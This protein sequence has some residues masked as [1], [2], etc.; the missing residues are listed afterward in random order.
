[1]KTITKI[2]ML[3]ALC[4]GLTF[5]FTAC[6]QNEEFE[7][8]AK[9]VVFSAA[10]SYENLPETKTEYSGEDFNLVGQTQG[11][12]RIDWDTF[13]DT[14]RV[15][16]TNTLTAANYK[17]TQIT[18][19]TTVR[20]VANV[21]ATGDKLTWST[22]NQANTFYAVYPYTAMNSGPYT[23][24][25]I[26]TVIGASIPA[27]QDQDETHEGKNKNTNP[28]TTVTIT[29][30]TMSKY[31]FMVAKVENAANG[32]NVTLPFVP[33]FTAFEFCVGS[34]NDGG[35]NT[36]ISKVE[37]TSTSTALTGAWTW[38]GSAFDCP[39]YSSS[40]NKITVNYTNNITFNNSSPLRFTVFALPQNLDNVSVTFY[41]SHG[42]K[43]LTFTGKTFTGGNKY[44]I[45]TPGLPT[46]GDW[47]YFL[48]EIDDITTYGHLA[49]SSDVDVVS[50]RARQVNGVVDMSTIQPVTWKSQYFDGTQW[51]DW[52]S[53][54]GDFSF[55]S[56]YTGSGVS[57][58]SNSETRTVSLVDNTN[59]S[60]TGH[61]SST[62][63]LRA[64]TPVSNYSL[65]D[66][67]LY[68]QSI[69]ASTANTYVVTAPGTYTF[70]AVY[71]NGIENAQYN[72][73]A[74]FP[75]ITA[76]NCLPQFRNSVNAGITDPWIYTDLNSGHGLTLSGVD[77]EVV[78][79][80]EEIITSKPSVRF[81]EG[82]Y[83]IDFAINASDIRPGNAVIALRGKC[84][85]GAGT[86]LGD[87]SILW[88]WQ[89]W[90]TDQNLTPVNDLMPFNLGWNVDGEVQTI[91]YTNRELPI[92][93]LQ[94]AP[95]DDQYG[96][97][98]H[99]DFTFTQL[100]DAAQTYEL[101]IGSNP[102]YQWG[103][104]DPMLPG[105]YSAIPN[106]R[107][108]YCEDRPFYPST[109]YSGMSS[110][111][112]DPGLQSYIEYGK[113]V[114]NPHKGYQHSV[115]TGWI[116]GQVTLDNVAPYNLW[117]A[118]ITSANSSGTGDSGSSKIKTV[119][120]P[121]PYGFTVPYQSK[122]TSFVQ[123]GSNG[124]TDGG[125]NFGSVFLPYAGA[126]IFYNREAWGE[127]SATN[128]G[129][130]IT[131]ALYLRHINEFG[132]YWTDTPYSDMRYAQILLFEETN[133]VQQSYTR[134]TAAAIR[135]MVDPKHPLT[136]PSS[137]SSL[138]KGNGSVQPV[139]N[140]GEIP[141]N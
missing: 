30:P 67:D 56:S 122:F 133:V 13:T 99:E 128:P 8:P 124:A 60:T 18:D 54:N 69:N 37:L 63:I 115:T 66:H 86:V 65:C 80:D 131:A 109:D 24:S 71:G 81:V 19:G 11:T 32:S 5:V 31:A 137:S 140:G 83:W 73:A 136:P 23:P 41:T 42:P 49:V 6:E 62:E 61:Q 16:N 82:N 97:I 104:K 46:D 14:I 132:L 91:Q 90:V 117:D 135:P 43:T 118:G 112:E 119:Y 64:R 21:A 129:P 87:N 85:N 77:A 106:V 75:N 141:A 138:N 72:T 88:S 101:A 9:E 2:S 38:N 57:N 74:Y 25:N 4:C 15:L 3:A 111:T 84:V 20:S 114:R 17:I 107:G 134:G 76:T 33:A 1:M 70:P 120:D 52:S 116:G 48:E 68:G 47:V 29:N 93:I 44:R 51:Q 102:Y 28:A 53:A 139:G 12:E 130:A 108:D 96:A 10:T 27:T 110:D 121:C 34:A 40:N 79:Q 92:R 98:Q 125:R 123:S 22:D 94:I 78:W 58:A 105:Q 103:R 35:T 50:Y 36:T 55:G 26:G 45:T 39:S 100:A 59:Y 89:I 113:G 126:R 127:Y 95:S 7:E